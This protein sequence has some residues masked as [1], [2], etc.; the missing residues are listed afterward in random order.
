MDM[1][2]SKEIATDDQAMKFED[3][4][5]REFYDDYGSEGKFFILLSQKMNDLRQH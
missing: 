3:D 4:I 5:D 1:I 2:R